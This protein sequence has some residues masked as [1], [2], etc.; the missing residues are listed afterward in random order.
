MAKTCKKCVNLSAAESTEFHFI[1][2]TVSTFVQSIACEKLLR[3]F[4][5]RDPYKRASLEL[6]IDDPWINEGYD[7]SPIQA[8]MSQPMVHDDSIVKL[9]EQRFKVDRETVMQSLADNAY[10]DIAACYYLLYYEKETRG[11]IESS[12]S[13]ASKWTRCLIVD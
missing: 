11:K 3:K 9:I 13:Y 7:S 2:Q 6:L 4:L 12:A 10:D 8:D 5:I 1:F